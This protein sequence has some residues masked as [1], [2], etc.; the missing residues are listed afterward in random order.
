MSGSRAA[1][2]ARTPQTLSIA[3][4]RDSLKHVRCQNF[5][6]SAFTIEDY[7]TLMV[8]VAVVRPK[9]FVA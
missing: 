2:L 4:H 5:Y 6:P 3:K 8:T 9:E 7:W 1:R